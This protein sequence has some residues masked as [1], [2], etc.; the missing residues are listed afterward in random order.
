MWLV[1]IKV[2]LSLRRAE[3]TVSSTPTSQG[4]TC[5]ASHAM[6][7]TARAIRPDLS[8]TSSLHLLHHCSGCSGTTLETTDWNMKFRRRKSEAWH[9]L[10]LRTITRPVP[11][12]T[13]GNRSISA[14]GI[15]GWAPASAGRRARVSALEVGSFSKAPHAGV[16]TSL[17][18]S[19]SSSGLSATTARTETRGGASLLLRICEHI[20]G[21]ASPCR[22]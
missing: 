12:T 7:L 1:F 6:W 3:L 17:R 5:M 21:I 8:T 15:M 22:A 4:L 2:P 13:E 14:M 20:F 10:F 18:G 9:V 11:L 19:V 16:K